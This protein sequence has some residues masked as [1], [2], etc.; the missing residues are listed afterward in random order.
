MPDQ[1][2]KNSQKLLNKLVA[3]INEKLPLKKAKLLA[4]F[5][6][7]YYTMVSYDDLKYRSIEDLFGSL[8]SMW[9][10]IYQRVPEECKIRIYN[11]EFEKHSWQSTHTIIE[12]SHDDMPFLVD[13]VRMTVNRLGI[14]VHLMIYTGGMK[15]SRNADHQ[16]TNILPPSSTTENFTTEAPIYVEID[17]QTDS[18]K[19]ETLKKT[20]QQALSDTTLAVKDWHN[21]KNYLQESI[22]NLDKSASAST[23]EIHESKD[24]LQW[25][26]DDHFIFFGCTDFRFTKL[27]GVNNLQ[28]VSSSGLGV[29]R[30]KRKSPHYFSDIQLDGKNLSKTSPLLTFAKTN[31]PASLHRDAYTDLVGIMRFDK[32]GEPIGERRFIG[33]YSMKAYNSNPCSIPLIR[34]KVNQVL[35]KSELVPIS[36]AGKTLLNILHALPRDDLFQAS[37]E[38]LLELSMGIL[39]LQERQ[40]VRLFIRKDAHNRFFSC[41]VFIPRD[42]FNTGLRQ[43]IWR[44]LTD[45]LHGESI[46]FVT[47]FSKSPLAQ[48]H[49]AVRINPDEPHDYDIDEIE[50]KIIDAS[51]T[52]HD[53]LRENLIEKY[54]EATGI[55]YANDYHRAF[56]ASYREQFDSKATISDI[57]YIENLTSQ[58]RFDL[59]FY[60][61]ITKN[62]QNLLHLKLFCRDHNTPLSD[63]LPMLENM[64]LRVIDESPHKI[65]LKDN[66]IVWINDFE[67]TL[68]DENKKINFDN[69]KDI[70]Q[71]AFVNVWYENIENDKFNRLVLAAELNWHETAMLR[72]YAK[73]FCQINFTFSQTYIEET[74]TEHATIAKDLANLFDARF[75]PH[76]DRS[77]EKTK[78][79]ENKI[80]TAL[81]ENV[82]SLDQ[83]RILRH[84]LDV[85]LATTRTNYF[86]NNNH[87]NYISFKFNPSKIPD[88]PL[89]CPMHEIF[90][91]SPRF[92]GIHLRG[93]EV[94]RGGLRWSDRK[95]DFRTEILGLMKAQ[96]VKNAVIIPL[97]AKGGFVPKRLLKDGTRDQIL[98]EGIN[99]YRGFIKGLL[100][101]TDN[102]KN[103][104]IIKPK[105][106][107][108]YDKNDPYLVVA[109]DKG[110]ATFSDIANEISREYGFWL[111]DAFASGGSAGYDHKKMGITARGAWES[112]KRHFRHLNIDTQATDF[113]VVG[114]GDMAG[115]VFGNGMLLSSHIKLIAAFNHLHIFINPNPDSKTSFE[116]RKRLFNLPRSSWMDYDAKKISKGGGVFARSAKYIKLS[117]EI[118]ELLNLSS[119]HITPNALIRAILTARA[120]LLWNGGIG[121]FVKASYETHSDAGDRTNDALRINANELRCKVIAEG[122]NLGFTQLAR[123]EFALN[124]GYVYTD[125][126]DNSAGVDCSDHEVNIKILLSNAIAKGELTKKQRNRLLAKMTGQI[127]QLVLKNNYNQTQAIDLIAAHSSKNLGLHSRVIRDLEQQGKINRELEY[128][129]DEEKLNIRKSLNQGLTK[130]EIAVLLAY[131]KILLKKDILNSDIPEDSYLGKILLAEFPNT[132]RKK[133][134]TQMQSHSLRREIIATQ[135]SNT[136]INEMGIAFLYRLKEETSAS[137]ASIVKAYAIARQIF[138]KN[139]LWKN[140]ETLDLQIP[141]D[142]QMHMLKR[143]GRLTRRGTRWL[144]RNRSEDLDIEKAISQFKKM[145]FNLNKH[146]PHILPPTDVTNMLSDIN[147]FIKNGVPQDIA[148]QVAYCFVLLSSLDIVQATLDSGFS[149]HSV[150]TAYFRLGAMLDLNWF[151]RYLINYQ[152]ETKWD[153][154]ARITF[155]DDLDKQQRILTVAA[156][157]SQPKHKSA[158]Y[159]I[160]YWIKQNTESIK[161]WQSVISN[162][163]TASEIEPI[164]FSVGLRELADLG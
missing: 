61:P 149:I 96:Q 110:T 1:D 35:K 108:C 13:S 9:D 99:C 76:T 102:L 161:R 32:K 73:Y 17:R 16:I 158:Q 67:M 80:L 113:T 101:I 43:K 124:G 20:L 41:L 22:K 28:R 145:I 103:Q 111:E 29:L 135:V 162:I 164:M 112:V 134:Y 45:S 72:A 95:E 139:Q 2:K 127:A 37:T 39:H 147:D 128:L 8:L 136:L 109:A 30:N 40:K 54:G 98:E 65:T 78:K 34:H 120:D 133:Y 50:E 24:F 157:K 27:K 19:I 90:V 87:K 18:K 88:L 44:I 89:P 119:N 63:V 155:R 11:P 46:T 132:L 105:N 138:A 33:L 77:S 159:R 156:L 114:I 66:T 107:V 74:L 42:H 53:A 71:N 82:D 23:D 14:F 150:A 5:A 62:N 100:D 49:F 84:Y 26:L 129:P 7:R 10:I 83:D 115:D 70:F 56:P 69:V 85:I 64:G 140:I 60:Q 148:E 152:I 144:L 86:Q 81:E 12:I 141:T 122:G 55:I 126:I 36:H 31:M 4:D 123:I 121:T 151:R 51:R 52:W 68:T 38:E 153:A 59:N 146:L 106:V 118:K 143:I 93:A 3:Y 75:N 160:D 91:Y 21:M 47:T 125:F 48:I 97:G 130:P 15:V 57:Q 116:E 137:T 131:N 79:L 92:E 142:V 117:S 6:N 25:L 58:K 154:L 104:E 94:A 163:K